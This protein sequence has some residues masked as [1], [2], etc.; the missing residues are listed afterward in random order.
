MSTT[1]ICKTCAHQCGLDW[2]VWHQTG[3]GTVGTFALCDKVRVTLELCPG[4]KI[5]ALRKDGTVREFTDCPAHEE[6]A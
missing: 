4:G 1:P 2:E 6:M 3:H 5:K